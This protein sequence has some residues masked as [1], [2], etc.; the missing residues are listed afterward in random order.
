[1]PYTILAVN[2]GSSSVKTRLFEVK[3]RVPKTLLSF[4]VSR[5]HDGPVFHDKSPER[6]ST[7]EVASDVLSHIDAFAHIMR[8]LSC[9]HLVKGVRKFQIDAIAHRVVHG[10]LRGQGA[11][12]TEESLRYI[13]ELA[14]FAPLHNYAAVTVIRTC[15]ELFPATKNYLFFDTAFHQTIAPPLRSYAIDQ[16][17]AKSRGLFKYGFHGIS[18]ASVLR[19]V[20]DFIGKDP[21]ECSLIVM[22]LGSGSSVCAIKQGQSLDTSMGLTPLS[23][24]P[25]ATRSGDVDPCLVFHYGKATQSPSLDVSSSLN[26]FEADDILSTLSGWASLTGTSNFAKI[27]SNRLTDPYRLAFEMFLDRI[28][29]FIGS[30]YLKLDGIVDALVF[31]GG[32]GEGS[33]Q[34]RSEVV[35]SCRCLGFLLHARENETVG[36]QQVTDISG[37]QDKRV[38]VCQTDEE[39]ELA[40]MCVGLGINESS[41]IY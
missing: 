5:I 27:A 15:K 14:C 18:Y 20:S 31:S 9:D 34:L 29:G 39:G 23:G 17:V 1:M 25:G 37:N 10:G 36:V 33:A 6:T 2:V 8:K 38:L 13:Q 28:I 30:Y 3:Q 35:R 4:H 40:H 26:A 32:I 12:V 41:Q 11:T 16:T 21:R 7:S 24:L 22:H 19:Q